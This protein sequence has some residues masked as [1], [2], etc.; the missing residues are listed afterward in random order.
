MKN[1]GSLEKLVIINNLLCSQFYVWN[2][3]QFYVWTA[4]GELARL[5]FRR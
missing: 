3:T 2:I 5:L 4:S 1:K